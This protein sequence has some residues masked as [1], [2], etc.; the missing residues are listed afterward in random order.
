MPKKIK[1]TKKKAIKTKLANPKDT[2]AS[3]DLYGLVGILVKSRKDLDKDS[4][5]RFVRGLRFSARI[6]YILRKKMG[7]TNLQVDWGHIWG[8]QMSRECDIIIHRGAFHGWNGDG[9]I[10]PV[11]NFKFVESKNVVAVISC[12]SLIR[13]GDVDAKFSA[14]TKAYSK[15]IFLFAEC[16]A[17]G[18]FKDVEKKVLKAGYQKFWCLYEWDAKN[19]LHLPLEPN[20]DEFSKYVQKLR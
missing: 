4:V 7:A 14:E 5:L 15:K 16:C 19:Q 10:N 1:K 20:I 8:K 9:G 12:K 17:L 18:K 3:E 2:L 13:P 11:M 6:I